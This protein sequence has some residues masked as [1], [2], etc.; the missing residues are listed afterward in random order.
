MSNS[1]LAIGSVPCPD[2][3]LWWYRATY[4]RNYDGDTATV[5]VDLGFK[6]SFEMNIRLIGINAP[7]KQTTTLAAGMAAGA[8][9]EQLI[10]PASVAGLL[11]LKTYKD[12]PD[13]YGARWLG[14]FFVPVR[15]EVGKALF[16]PK[17]AWTSVNGILL[18]M[19]H[20]VPYN[21]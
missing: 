15:Q 18:T 20:A 6:H 17:G 9:L 1:P 2:D 11:R 3:S 21:P 7:E 14:E 4:V 13:K 19:G 8:A 10:R 12:S 16:D 5:L